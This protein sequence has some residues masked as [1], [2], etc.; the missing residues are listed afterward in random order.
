MAETP[1]LERAEKP[2]APPPLL[3]IGA[4]IIGITLDRYLPL[5]PEW[6]KSTLVKGVGIVLFVLAH[7]IFLAAFLR[8]KKAGT[9]LPHWKP[10]TAL[11]S[12][13][14]YAYTRNPVYVAMTSFHIGIALI[15]K[16]T[17]MLALLP[18]LLIV[19]QQGVIKREEAYLREKFGQA[20]IDYCAR[21]RRWL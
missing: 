21:V 13:G 12:N 2:L 20:Y 6:P 16:S 14:I 9:Y 1:S 7:I 10:T 4:F 8:F 3:Y 5:L 17:W 19:M 11:V 15:E 18:P